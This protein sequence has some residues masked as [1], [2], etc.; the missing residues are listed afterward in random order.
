V[1]CSREKEA[2]KGT[3]FDKGKNG[4]GNGSSSSILFPLSA[5][6][7]DDESYED[8]DDTGDWWH[9][10]FHTSDGVNVFNG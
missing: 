4:M 3:E 9:D 8:R 2:Y 6:S 5:V 7:N 10:D 1:P